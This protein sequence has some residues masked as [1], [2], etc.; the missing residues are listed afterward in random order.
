MCRL[1]FAIR[2]IGLDWIVTLDFIFLLD[3]C[4]HWHL[5]SAGLL[6]SKRMTSF[7]FVWPG[8]F[9]T[10]WDETPHCDDLSQC[11]LWSCDLCHMLAWCKNV[12]DAISNVKNSF[13]MNLW[14]PMAWK[15][16]LIDESVLC[17]SW[18]HCLYCVQL[19]RCFLIVVFTLYCSHPLGM[20]WQPLAH[21]KPPCVSGFGSAHCICLTL[22]RP[23]HQIG[24]NNLID[25]SFDSHV[26][27]I[28]ACLDYHT[29]CLIVVFCL[30]KSS[31]CHVYLHDD[32]MHN[33]DSA[34]ALLRWMRCFF[35]SM[36]EKMIG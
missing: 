28:L 11:L 21:T 35:F 33:F 15:G 22:L 3:L 36:T 16:N 8:L 24:A 29:C 12:D 10:T 19:E 26:F 2:L 13:D 23:L 31:L 17:L 5:R 14:C 20:V 4:M 9:V 25:S 1:H 27:F 32:S 18:S 34:S 30:T 6:A 7:E